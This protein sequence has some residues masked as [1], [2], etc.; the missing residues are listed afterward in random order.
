MA[1]LRISI[2]RIYEPPSK[3][4]GFRVLVDRVWPRGISRKDAA[5]DRWAKDI[6]PSTE[7]RK[8]F[9]HRPERWEEFRKR[10][11]NELASRVSDLRHLAEECGGCRMTL[12]FSAKDAD[13]NQAVVLKDVLTEM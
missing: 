13:R 10:Y 2:K 7:L 4:D 12:I 5:I 6:A 9:S 11:R 1:L 3:E 8:W